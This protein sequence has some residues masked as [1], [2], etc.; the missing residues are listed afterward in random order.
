MVYKGFGVF[1]GYVGNGV[2]RINLLKYRF[3][4]NS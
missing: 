3:A 2:F 4:N 1:Y